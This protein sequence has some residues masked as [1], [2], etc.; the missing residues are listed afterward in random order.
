ME[1]AEISREVA[2]TARGKCRAL[3]LKTAQ[4]ALLLDVSGSTWRRWM[5]SGQARCSLRVWRRLLLFT[6]G[7]FDGL[8]R[9]IVFLYEH[10]ASWEEAA[11]P[12]VR[13]W[14]TAI[15]SENAKEKLSFIHKESLMRYLREAQCN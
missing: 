4:I 14:H 7:F 1:S 10:E 6:E 8:A 12:L 3:G 9:Q 11:R 13:A 2:E 15:T 5:R